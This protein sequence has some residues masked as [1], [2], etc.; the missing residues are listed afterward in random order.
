MTFTQFERS[1]KHYDIFYQDRDYARDTEIIEQHIAAL[2]PSALSILDVACGCH[3]HGPHLSSRFCIDGLENN[4]IF[5]EQA[6]QKTSARAH[7]GHYHLASMDDFALGK[8]YDVIVC[9][10]SSIAYLPDTHSLGAAI[11]CF[12]KHLAEKG[13]L[14]IEPWLDPSEIS[15]LSPCKIVENSDIR[16]CRM[17]SHIVTGNHLDLSLHYMVM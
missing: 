16:I 6:V 5:L 2:N 8:K 14:L 17:A 10:F 11:E 3:A 15:S 1:A 12:S 9:L 4:E 13:I 7:A